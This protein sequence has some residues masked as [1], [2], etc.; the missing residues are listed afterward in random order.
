M[1]EHPAAGTACVPPRQ[2][3]R[4]RLILPLTLLA[5]LLLLVL[6]P[7][8]AN[9]TLLQ[10]MDVEQLSQHAS[11]IVEGTVLSTRVEQPTGEV[12][13]AVRIEVQRVLKGSP[14]AVITCYVPGGAVPDGTVVVVDG[15]PSFT[16]GEQCYV[17]VDVRGWVIAGFQGK[18]AVDGGRVLSQ[19]VGLRQMDA[20]I[21]A[22]I[23]GTPAPKAV[24]RTAHAAK[25]WTG[26]D[27]A[28]SWSTGHL[29]LKVD[30]SSVTGTFD[31]VNGH[32]AVRNF[33]G[34]LNDDFAGM[35]GTFEQEVTQGAGDWVTVRFYA[36]LKPNTDPLKFTGDYADPKNKIVDMNWVEAKDYEPRPTITAITPDVASAGTGSKI[37]ITGL[38][39]GTEKGTVEFS[40]GYEGIARVA[41]QDVL[42]WTD[43][44]IE[45]VVPV[46]GANDG[47][48]RSASSGPLWVTTAKGSE[49]PPFTFFVSFGYSG[50]KFSS[51][52][53]TYF[54]NAKGVAGTEGFVDAAAATWNAAGAGFAFVD[55]GPT[56]AGVAD[57]GHCVI[58]W[59]DLGTGYVALTYPYVRGTTLVE[60]DLALNTN[61]EFPFGDGAAGTG[62][63][64]IRTTATHELGHWLRLQDLYGTAD[65]NKV[66]FGYTDP[67]RVV[68]VLNNDD[69]A[70]IRWIYPGGAPVPDADKT[71]PVCE[72]KS[73]TVRRG[74]VATLKVLAHDDQGTKV[75]IWVDIL[76]RNGTNRKEFDWG[77]RENRSGWW[78]AR[79]LCTLPKGKY[80][81]NVGAEDQA[82]NYGT[83]T[84]RLTVI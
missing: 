72:A 62:T 12:R 8:A 56:N 28:G 44:R 51:G 40:Y 46:T 36:D 45:C 10:K 47:V 49:G 75:K 1:S 5:A 77:W 82:G 43:T 61:A 48:K 3:R 71:K 50:L 59:D 66:M 6:A 14:G 76:D 39:F 63:Y 84:A 69:V 60:N 11:L 24:T 52:T 70:G 16:P 34:Q 55:G 35:N 67:E 65:E 21:A 23:E 32:G 53:V 42:S 58:T 81:I 2:H 79:W 38:R 64:D 83:G 15:M 54:V 26:A 27:W 37:V 33:V 7:A 78:N 68:R 13:T 18:L 73:V 22:A 31:P 41:A 57:D 19:D 80:L 25:A 30:G 4:E 20:R 29:I 17:F 74:E 9:A